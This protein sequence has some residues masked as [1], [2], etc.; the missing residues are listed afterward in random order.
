MRNARR[1]A[2]GGAKT[3]GN[4]T[5][6]V[7]APSD[8]EVSKAKKAAWDAEKERVLQGRGTRDWTPSQQVELIRTGQVRGFDCQHMKSR[9]A[10]PQYAADPNNFQFLTYEEHI[11]GAHQSKTKVP[12][13]GR[14]DPST[15]RMIPFSEN[16][17]PSNPDFPLTSPIDPTQA[18][19]LDSLGRA[20]GY[21]R[22]ADYESSREAQKK[23]CE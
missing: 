5:S 14:F 7:S 4:Q 9:N 2:Q 13:N 1:N 10:Y 3:G 11:R 17:P 16:G 8:T 6:G 23:K 20:F 12:T 21:G 19:F 15:G 18:D 22:G